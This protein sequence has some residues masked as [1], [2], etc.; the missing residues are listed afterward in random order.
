MKFIKTELENVLLI[1]PCIVEDFRGSFTE[2]YNEKEF[3]E[4]GI[5]VKFVQDDVSISTN[6]VLRGLHGDLKTHKIVSCIYGRIYLVVLNCD[7]K[8]EQYGKWQSF[9][10]SEENKKQIYIPPKFANGYYVLSDKAIF[11]YKQSTY[12]GEAKQFSVKW[13][14]DRYNIWWPC[15]QPCLSPRDQG[16][17]C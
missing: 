5:K 8:S 7:E 6:N 12:Y 15:V 13:N 16:N 1:E 9:I 10:L 17:I 4:N 14:D 11:S 3:Y 2:V